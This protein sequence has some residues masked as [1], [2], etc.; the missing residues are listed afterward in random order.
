[1]TY[2]E[3]VVV[4]SIFSVI[5]GVV[6]F[7][8]RIFQDKVNIKDVAYE[9]AILLNQAQKNSLSGVLPKTLT[10][11]T[12]K[13][14]Y[15][16]YFNLNNNLPNTANNIFYYFTDLNQD[17]RYDT[18]YNCPVDEC[19]E[20]FTISKSNRIGSIILYFQD[21]T[22]SSVTSD[23]HITYTRP[24]T[25]ATFYTTQYSFSSPVSYAEIE[26]LSN[27]VDVRTKIVVHTSGRID[28]K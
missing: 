10:S 21:G 7:N 13:P 25:N 19:I 16:I 20:K 3:L 14:S 28:I 15:G 17:K 4:F 26:L 11:P 2:L 12:W 23:L 27:S 24:S 5:Y 1:M 6:L 8:Y 9:I 18:L 22:F